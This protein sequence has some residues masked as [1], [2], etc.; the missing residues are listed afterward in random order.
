MSNIRYE[1]ED[2][3]MQFEYADV[4]TQLKL[5]VAEYNVDDDSKLLNWIK[6]QSNKGK[7]VIEI[8]DNQEITSR[9][10]YLICNL[11]DSK[12]GSIYCKVCKEMYMPG[13]I[14]K[15]STSPFDRRISSKTI[16]KLRKFHKKEFG[17]KGPIN[18]PGSGG[19]IYKCPKEHILISVITWIT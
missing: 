9:F 6:K 13:K 16:R 2:V 12:K 10:C 8:G 5:K 3:V 17:S 1:N 19:K 18:I 11:I 4:I 14:I 15:E 7:E